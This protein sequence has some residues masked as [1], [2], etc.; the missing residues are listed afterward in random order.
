MASL[1]VLYDLAIVYSVE[2]MRL[3]GGFRAARLPRQATR[4]ARVVSLWVEKCPVHPPNRRALDWSVV[5]TVGR[6]CPII[7][8]V[9]TVA[10]NKHNRP[11]FY[12]GNALVCPGLK[13]PMMRLCPE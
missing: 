12:P 13:P 3:S 11:Q 4:T 8:Q 9:N 5:L 7:L 1:L 6:L 10:S 2:S